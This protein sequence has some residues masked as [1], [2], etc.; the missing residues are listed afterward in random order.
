MAELEAYIRDS[1][2]KEVEPL[3]TAYVKEHPQSSWGW[4]ALGYS[5]FA[6]Q[7]IGESIQDSGEVS[8][9][10]FKEC[11][12]AQDP[13]SRFDDHREIRCRPD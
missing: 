12:S 4:Y 9:T 5:L 6:Q 3:L 1:K 7:K 10:Q 13:G 2:F 8:S 11:R